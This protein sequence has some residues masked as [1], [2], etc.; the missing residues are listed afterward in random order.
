MRI[1]AALLPV[2]AACANTTNF[3]DW[4]AAHDGAPPAGDRSTVDYYVSSSE[5]GYYAGE[6]VVYA[7]TSDSLYKVDPATLKVTLIAAFKWPM[8]VSDQMTDIALDKKG[9]MIGISFGTVYGINTTTAA[10]TRLADLKTGNFNG[11]SYIFS[12]VPDVAENLWAAAQDGTVSSVDSKTGASKGAGSYNGPGSSGDI[13]SVKGLGTFATVK[14][15]PGD[16]GTDWLA[17]LNTLNGQA[18][19]IGDTTFTSIW[20]LGFWKNKFYGF[21]EF[22]E[23]VLIDPKTG[24]GS[25]V[26][27]GGPAWWGAGVTTAAP[28][29]Q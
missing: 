16:T 12:E 9:N 7:H 14:R 28:V 11:L 26:E 23:F 10:C 18:T 21:T 2:L 15:T 19:L 24:K 1:F 20:G 27:K 5:G 8:G 4:G 6:P 3:P 13:V 22:G 25:L 17:R 29:L